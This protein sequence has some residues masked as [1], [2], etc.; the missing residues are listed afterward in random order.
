[1]GLLSI[2]LGGSNRDTPQAQAAQTI[3]AQQRLIDEQQGTISAQQAEIVNLRATIKSLQTEVGALHGILREQQAEIER[4]GRA[5]Q[6][7]ATPF[8]KGERKPNPKKPGRKP[9]ASN[10]GSNHFTFR[11]APAPDTITSPVVEVL[12]DQGAYPACPSCAGALGE[13]QEEMAYTTDMPEKFI[14][15]VKA[16]RVQVCRCQKC[17]KSVRATHPDLAKDQFGASA[18]RLGPRV[19]AAAHVL[20]LVA[21]VTLRKTPAIIK[22]LTGI[23]LTQGAIT[24]D[25]LRRNKAP[26][27][28][29]NGERGP[30]GAIWQA[31]EQLRAEIKE[32]Q[33]IY[34]DD[35]GWKINGYNAYLMG[36]ETPRTSV[37]QI[38]F[39]H[40]NEEVREVI[41][42][43]YPGTMSTDRGRSYDAT[44]FNDV[45]QNKCASHVLRSID[46]VL[47][48]KR[49][50]KAEIEEMAFC[51]ELKGL[52]KGAVA[53][54]KEYH[55]DQAVDGQAVNGQAVDYAQ[56][57]AA[58]QKSMTIVLRNRKMQDPDDQRLL[59]QLGWHHD[60]GNLLRFLTDPEVEPTNNRAER[61]LRPAVIARKVSQCSKNT[62]GADA[63]AAFAS[64]LCTLKKR[65]STPLIDALCEVFQTGRVQCASP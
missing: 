37:F 18:H 63:Y 49:L 17:G 27:I 29:P 7:S 28:N 13:I 40:R 14:P 39:R 46:A 1:M 42:G 6:R 31:S 34:T 11:D 64:V 4:L 44:E 15:E 20:H 41:P 22:E 5:G 21:G 24:Q 60:R 23:T 55:T 32:E 30:A 50:R 45:K 57:A 12:L 56:Q 38:R 33:V 54:W 48:K 19:M 52:L 16:Y 10:S 8:S 3:L 65:V 35:T 62:Q 2:I 51:L 43:D 36:F 9:R 58:I 47:E 25:M 59:D 26:G 61:G 53:L